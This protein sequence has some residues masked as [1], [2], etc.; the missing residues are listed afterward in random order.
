MP[1]IRPFKQIIAFLMEIIEQAN[2]APNHKLPSERMLA[3]K[4]SASRR[5]I[6]LAY[7]NL[8]THGLVVKIHGKGHF[9]TGKDTAH[10]AKERL[11]IKKIYFIVP[12]LETTFTRNILNGITDFCDEHT[13][14]VSVKISKGSLK[15]ET[16]YLDFAFN[17]DT[18]GIILFPNDNDLMNDAVHAELIKLSASRYPVA[19]ID[20]YYKNIHSSFISTDNYNAMLEAVKFLHAKKHNHLLFLTPPNT[21][22]TSVEERLHGYKDG[23]LKYY[24]QTETSGFIRFENFGFDSVYKGVYEYLKEH[25]ETEVIIAPGTRMS[26]DA[27]IAAVQDAKKD[28][29][30]NIKL[31]VF[32]SDFS[33]TELNLFR[34]YVILQDAYQIGY[35][36]AS[37]L[38]NQIYGDLRVE[39]VR[40]PI[41]IVDYTKKHSIK[42]A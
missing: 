24:G 34:P 30:K 23:L 32:D 35:K 5:S 37:T 29:P 22:A 2:Y 14:D 33:S 31:M 21:L 26:T 41:S 1:T 42:K 10:N 39:M 19:I 20:R 6:R 15:K 9:T 13:M 17:S 4:F 12:N 3:N 18:K 28:L 7:E 11:D 16:Q 38:Y 27:V 25:P 8:I 40:L 36:S